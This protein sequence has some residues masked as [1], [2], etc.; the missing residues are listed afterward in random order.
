MRAALQ[1]AMD[2]IAAHA[3]GA[4]AGTNPEHLHQ[5]RVATRRMRAALR[6]SRAL[7]RKDD[8]R[9]LRRQLRELA[10]VSG[11]A[12][13]WDVFLRKAPAPLRARALRRQRKAHA[14]LRRVL[15]A[16]QPLKLPRAARGARRDW[17]AFAHD[18]LEHLDRRA[19]RRAARIDWGSAF[20]RHALRI[21]LRQLRY[22][23]EFTSGAFRGRRAKALIRSLKHLQ[24]LLGELNDLAVAR[25]LTLQLSGRDTRPK[26]RERKLLSQL[27]AAWRQFVASPRFWRRK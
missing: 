15:L 11:P 9:A 12:R 21:R 16:M 27:T 5:L 19:L 17:P 13:D 24:D 20:E 7:W 3:P 23:S 22:V 4:A 6:A 1:Q 8:V 14:A 10:A 26:E 18:A 2:Q 25:R